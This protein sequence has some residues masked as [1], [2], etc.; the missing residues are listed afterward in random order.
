MK[1]TNVVLFSFIV[2][3]CAVADPITVSNTSFRNLYAAIYYNFPKIPL[4]NQKPAQLASA[5]TYIPAQSCATLDRPDLWYTADRMLV[6]SEENNLFAPTVDPALLDAWNALNIGS[7]QGSTFYLATDSQGDINGYSA[8]EWDLIEEPIQYAQEMMANFLPAIAKN[9]YKTT[10]A[11]VR[12]GNQLCDQERAYLQNRVQWVEAALAQQGIAC[13]EGK[14]VPTIAIVCSGGGYRAMLYALGALK[15]FQES[16]VLDLSTY[17]VGLSGSTWAIAPWICSGQT[18]DDYISGMLQNITAGFND[19]G[20]QTFSLITDVL[21]TKYCAGQP[22][23]FVD[24]YGAFVGNAVFTDFATQKVLVH[25]SDQAAAIADGSLPFPLYTCISG[26]TAQSEKLWYE[27]S[28]YEVG[29][30][31]LGAYVPTWAF[32]RRFENGASVTM[33]PEQPMSTLLGTFGLAV[34]VTVARMLSEAD[35]S[36]NVSSSLAKAL[37]QK[38]LAG[39]GQ[40]RP[41]YAQ[42]YNMVF[43]MS[44]ETFA[45]DAIAPMVDAGIDFNLPYPPISG[46]R[47]ERTADIILFV[48]ASADQVMGTEL[49]NVENYAQAHNL[50]FPAIDYTNIA[51]Q[52][53]SSFADS[54]NPDAPIVIYIPRIVDQQLLAQHQQDLPNLYNQLISFNVEQCISDGACNT[55][56]FDYTVAQAQQMMALGEFNAL[57][58][59]EIVLNALR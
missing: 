46:Q 23:G 48:D 32:G 53:V 1:L 28:P 21:L 41:I 16:G 10:S 13:A 58:A 24:L 9:P 44:D 51:R 56:N 8:L 35:I 47:T 12:L 31:W 30:S 2:V 18:I 54:S 20:E 38:I 57:M 7:L 25:L 27:F 15:G 26:Q 39:Y 14:K 45:D 4:M 19:V 50:P 33:A 3:A 5:I 11:T 37:I 29:A 52:A 43:N 17:L 42:Y 22:L 59:K 49:Q 34:G 55:F 40:D 6:F 36:T